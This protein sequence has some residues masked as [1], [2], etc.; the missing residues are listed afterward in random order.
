LVLDRN[1]TFRI[2]SLPEDEYDAVHATLIT[3]DALDTG[4]PQPARGAATRRTDPFGGIDRLR[5]WNKAHPD[6]PW[7]K[8]LSA[9]FTKDSWTA[10][11]NEPGFKQATAGGVTLVD[12]EEAVPIKTEV[13]NGKE[14]GDLVRIPAKGNVPSTLGVVVADGFAEPAHRPGVKGAVLEADPAEKRAWRAAVV[15]AG[16]GPG[17]DTDLPGVKALTSEYKQVSSERKRGAL[18][19]QVARNLADQFSTETAF[20]VVDSAFRYVPYANAGNHGAHVRDPAAHLTANDRWVVKVPDWEDEYPTTFFLLLSPRQAYTREPGA[21]L[22]AG[23]DPAFHALVRQSVASRL[24]DNW[25]QTSNDDD[26]VALALQ[27]AIQDEFGI[28]EGEGAT[29]EMDKRLAKEVGDEYRKRGAEYRAFVRAQY[30]ATQK[31]LAERGITKL[32]VYR[33]FDWLDSALIP[34]WAQD[35]QQGDIVNIPLRPASSWTFSEPTARSFA[36]PEADY[37]GTAVRAGEGNVVSAWVPASRVLS[38]PFTGWGCIPEYEMVILG[39][40]TRAK[41]V[42]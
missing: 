30:E 36:V 10:W 31:F 34:E 5:V 40:P 22:Y 20:N 9:P 13:A 17:E 18:K 32:A 23:N 1:S 25:A 24:I 42:L 7:K 15:D 37:F 11:R 19:A 41:V 29:W 2:D 8:P 27:R 4:G 16:P 38:T 3:Q 26:P 14:P 6:Q 35:A 12:S 33:G 28:E 39:G 21:T